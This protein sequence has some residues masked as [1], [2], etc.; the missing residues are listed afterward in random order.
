MCT[1]EM[2]P[3][4]V[5]IEISTLSFST[6]FF[7]NAGTCLPMDRT[8]FSTRPSRGALVTW[9]FLRARYIET[10]PRLRVNLA[11]GA[12]RRSDYPGAGPAPRVP[13]DDHEERG[14]AGQCIEDECLEREGYR[15][16]D[17]ADRNQASAAFSNQPT[18][19]SSD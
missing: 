12:V 10:R 17:R 8:A 15:S 3:M 4:D 18:G 19:T 6:V 11:D 2:S 13:E 5:F 7:E 1:M 9:T 16:R 14:Q